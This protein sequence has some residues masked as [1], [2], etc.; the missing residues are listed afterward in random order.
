M[1]RAFPIAMIASASR[2]RSTRGLP[3]FH[4]FSGRKIGSCYYTIVSMV[5]RRY[6][7][8]IRLC[9]AWPN[10]LRPLEAARPAL[11][12][13]RAHGPTRRIARRGEADRPS[14]FAVRCGDR[15]DH[16]QRQ[17]AGKQNAQKHDDVAGPGN[18][19]IEVFDTD[20][21]LLRRFASQGELNSP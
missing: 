15:R 12:R 13:Q 20:G 6:I 14:D 7:C 19:F 21:H 10:R 16:A 4:G 2:Q 1:A 3:E 5:K 8:Y 11:R 9:V 17:P 18:G